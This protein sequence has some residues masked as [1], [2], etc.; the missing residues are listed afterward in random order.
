VRARTGGVEDST[1][2]RKAADADPVITDNGDGASG[3]VI[4]NRWK[5]GL[6]DLELV[7]R[8]AA[9]EPPDQHNRRTRECERASR[10]PK[11]VSAEMST[12]FSARALKDGAVRG[13]LQ[14]DVPDVHRVL[15]SRLEPFGK[16]R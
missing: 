3:K 10:L 14:A 4:S 15:P 13:S 16:Q 9:G 6:D 1:R 8:A 7:R 11:S 12:R 5:V 2:Q